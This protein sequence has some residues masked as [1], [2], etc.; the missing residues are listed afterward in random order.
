[1]PAFAPHSMPP[2]CTPRTT[3]IG[4]QTG[5]HAY[6]DYVPGTHPLTYPFTLKIR[7][8][9]INIMVVGVVMRRERLGHKVE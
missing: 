9:P 2:V 3:P 7:V 1:M 8:D 5:A 6:V 4:C